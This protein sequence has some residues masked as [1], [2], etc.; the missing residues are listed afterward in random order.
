MDRRRDRAVEVD[1]VTDRILWNRRPTDP[2]DGG[3]IDEI[4]LHGVTVHIEQ[5]DRRCWWIGIERDGARWCGN[6]WANS[7]GHMTFMEQE[8]EGIEF[9]V[10]HTH[11][12]TP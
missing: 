9:T 7:R 11:E 1:A 12:V 5:M 2:M 3:D 4:V 10:D 6:F 8:N